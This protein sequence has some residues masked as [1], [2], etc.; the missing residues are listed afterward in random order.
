MLLP[1]G[2]TQPFIIAG[3]LFLWMISGIMC[4][5]VCIYPIVTMM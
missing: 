4:N 5:F 2:S 3:L 1:F